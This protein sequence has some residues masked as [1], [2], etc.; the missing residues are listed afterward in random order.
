MA[1][2]ICVNQWYGIG[3]LA[4]DAIVNE[5]NGKPYIRFQMI[6]GRDYG[7]Q[8]DVF[9]VAMYGD[10]VKNM[11]FLKKGALVFVSGWIWTKNY[12]DE[13]TKRWQNSITVNAGQV[14]LLQPRK[15]NEGEESPFVEPAG[16]I[17]FDASEDD[18]SGLIGM[19][20]LPF[21]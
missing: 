12:K 17:S 9:P 18:K 15:K 20:D 7:E 5:K 1:F 6:C 8:I 19:E 14:K 10:R 4:S 11:T 21:F 13:L 2:N 16:E 3:R